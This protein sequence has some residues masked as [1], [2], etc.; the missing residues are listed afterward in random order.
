MNTQTISLDVTKPA[1]IPPV[2][3]IGQGDKSGTTLVANI[4][5]DGTALTLTSYSVK[6]CIQTPNGAGYYE[7]DGTVSGST[8]T[9]AIDETYA[10]TVAGVS[11]IA[12]VEIIS[13]STVICSTNRFTVVVLQNGTEGAD[14][15][16]AYTNGVAQFLEDAQEQL[17]DAIEGALSTKADADGYYPELSVGTAKKLEGGTE[18]TSVNANGKLHAITVYGESVQNGTPTPS[19]PVP[20]QVVKT[21]NLLDT[22]LAHLTAANTSGTWS[23]DTYTYRGITMKVNDDGTLTMSGTATGSYTFYIETT[24]LGLAPGS[25]YLAACPSGGSQS[26]YYTRV[27]TLNSSGTVVSRNNDNGSGVAFTVTSEEVKQTCHIH[28]TSGDSFTT[29]VTISP[30]L[31]VGSTATPYIPYGYIV[32]N[33]GDTVMPIDLQG[34]V[35]ASL[36]NGVCDVLNIDSAGHVTLTKRVAVVDIAASSW[37]IRGDGRYRVALSM[38]GNPD[39]DYANTISTAYQPTNNTSASQPANTFRIV[40]AGNWGNLGA[41]STVVDATC[42]YPLATAQ[43]IDL[44]YI[45][46]PDITSG[47]AISVT[48][49]VT[50]TI[51]VSQSSTDLDAYELRDLS[52][53]CVAPIENGKA[54]TNYAV[55]AYLVHG[56]TLYRVTS[57]IASGESITPGTNVTATTVMAEIIRLTA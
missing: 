28:L 27:T 5:D 7:C 44:G 26:T 55:G 51:R 46:M 29:P 53:A 57:A 11:K 47:E 16:G 25:Y 42:Y 30:T 41:N 23:G 21:V 22:S 24:D 14:P 50:P 54:S 3:T 31:N 52:L 8:A 37:Q 9:F 38:I 20:V 1:A 34:N 18:G 49:S 39:D 45:D 32:L 43:T 36:P 13:G 17:D 19:A 4:Y 12:Y 15:S 10:G 56:G 33:C 40:A 35:L 48:A 2:V 6:L